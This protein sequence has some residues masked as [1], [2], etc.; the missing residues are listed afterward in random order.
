MIRLHVQGNRNPWYRSFDA[1]IVMRREYEGLSPNG[2][3]FG[4]NWVLRSD[5][6]YM[7]HDQYRYDLAARH[8]MHLEYI[9]G[10]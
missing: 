10:K 7:D 2:N 8:D 9:R 5:G 1:S 6:V 3:P 4:G